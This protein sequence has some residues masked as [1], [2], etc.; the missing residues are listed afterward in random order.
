MAV[1]GIGASIE[2]SPTQGSTSC[3]SAMSSKRNKRVLGWKIG[4]LA[5]EDIFERSK[6][7]A[8]KFSQAQLCRRIET[9]KHDFQF[10]RR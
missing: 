3:W 2:W 1:S 4:D 10:D 8:T 7:V 6:E 9:K 5:E